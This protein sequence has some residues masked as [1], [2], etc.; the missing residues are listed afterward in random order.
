MEAAGKAE[1]VLA[2]ST[3]ARLSKETTVRIGSSARLHEYDS[4]KAYLFST[5]RTVEYY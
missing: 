3:V 1:N 2:T 4:T 5:G